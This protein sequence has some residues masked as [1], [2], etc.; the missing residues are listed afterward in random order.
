MQATPALL[1]VLMS[2]VDQQTATECLQTPGPQQNGY[3]VTSVGEL[4]RVGA[5]SSPKSQSVF[6]VKAETGCQAMSVE[7]GSEK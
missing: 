7:N 1:H 6:F 5:D 4:I 2:P 3:P